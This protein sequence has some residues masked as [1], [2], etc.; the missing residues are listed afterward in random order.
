MKRL[1]DKRKDKKGKKKLGMRKGGERTE[2]MEEKRIKG[3]DV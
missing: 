2:E 1:G 3:R